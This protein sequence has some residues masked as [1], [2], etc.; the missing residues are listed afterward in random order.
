[1]GQPEVLPFMNRAK[2]FDLTSV[3]FI[4]TDHDETIRSTVTGAHLIWDGQTYSLWKLDGGNWAVTAVDGVY[5]D[6]VH[7]NGLAEVQ[8]STASGFVF[9]PDLSSQ[10]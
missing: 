1:M 9:A 10:E 7:L 2:A 3:Q 6:T 5:N 4:I 8:Q